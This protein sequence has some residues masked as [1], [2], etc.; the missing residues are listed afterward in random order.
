MT[1][2]QFESLIPRE[3][4]V[5]NIRDGVGYTFMGVD[6]NGYCRLSGLPVEYE[7]YLI[8]SCFEIKDK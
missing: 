2:E 7:D 4:M 1:K 3:S 8:I 6:K 5:Y